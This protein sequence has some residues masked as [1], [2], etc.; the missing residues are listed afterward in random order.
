MNNP[1]FV[2]AFFVV[3]LGASVASAQ[4]QTKREVSKGDRTNQHRMTKPPGPC[5]F[6]QCD[7]A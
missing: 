1:M 4:N 5:A 6:A 7:L 2:L 3:S